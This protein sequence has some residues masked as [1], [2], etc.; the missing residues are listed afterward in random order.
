[1][2]DALEF[3]IE[4]I[5]L[6]GGLIIAAILA[7]LIGGGR[8]RRVLGIVL[9]LAAMP[10]TS[11][12]AALPLDAS[13]VAFEAAAP[14]MV[15]DAV[16]VYGAGVFADPTG[17]MWPSDGSLNR[18]AVGHALSQRLDLPLVVS[19]GVSRPDL[20]AEVFV[21]AEV[22][23]LPADTVLEDQ[24]R[25]T[26]ENAFH[27]AAIARDRGWES[28]VLVTSRDHTR[29]A[30]AASLTAGLDVAAVV[31]ATELKEIQMIEFI[32]GIA[33]LG[34]W[35]PIVHEY[36]GILWYVLTGKIEMGTLAV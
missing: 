24:A 33:G 2:L 26:A 3:L 11:R 36:V 4:R 35:A 34:H 7:L 17:K 13:T 25:T 22:L 16:V 15:G 18:T 32:P 1:M 27:V 29:R 9:L 21:V 19:G 5:G 8:K 14:G 23:K 10:V 12:I 20:A 30:L 6:G 31:A 28:V